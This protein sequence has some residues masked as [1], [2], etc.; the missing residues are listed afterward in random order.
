MSKKKI[1]LSK[2][3]ELKDALELS[4]NQDNI[5]IQNWNSVIE[6]TKRVVDI[7]EIETLKDLKSRTITRLN[8]KIQEANFQVGKGEKEPNAY[9]IKE[10]SEL[11]RENIHLRNLDTT[12][13]SKLVK[14]KTVKYNAK[15]KFADITLRQKEIQKTIAQYKQK[16]TDFNNN[17]YIEID[18]N[19]INI[20]EL[21][22]V[23]I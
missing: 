8:L 2:A 22:N 19:V 13:G 1:K 14:G 9:Y 17:T 15:L 3:I 5:L 23:T 10:L 20:A 16:L 7:D 6:G 11:Q 18:E 21:V 4:I 12:D